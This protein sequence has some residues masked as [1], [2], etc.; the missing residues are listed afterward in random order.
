M[1]R[2]I[3]IGAVSFVALLVIGSI[4]AVGF[5]STGSSDYYQSD[6]EIVTEGT[7]EDEPTPPHRLSEPAPTYR[8]RLHSF[9]LTHYRSQMQLA[10][11]LRGK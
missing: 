8:S 2:K 1:T 4:V 10:F 6:P 3:I 7:C 11:R 5:G 9:K